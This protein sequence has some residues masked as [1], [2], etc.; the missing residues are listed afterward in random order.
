[1]KEKKPRAFS[2]KH[3]AVGEGSSAIGWFVVRWFAVATL[4]GDWFDDGR[5]K[6]RYGYI[7]EV[8][9]PVVSVG[10]AIFVV[11]D[12]VVVFSGSDEDDGKV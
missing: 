1:V 7:V 10:G 4:V 3:D 5:E 12:G 8:A 9:I 11:L 2:G 6:R